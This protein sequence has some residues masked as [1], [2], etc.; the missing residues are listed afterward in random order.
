MKGCPGASLQSTFPTE[1]EMNEP[2]GKEEENYVVPHT[3]DI[4]PTRYAQ[5]AWGVTDAS[6]H[7][8]AVPT[9]TRHLLDEKKLLT[10]STAALDDKIAGVETR[11]MKKKRKAAA[12]KQVEIAVVADSK[13]SYAPLIFAFLFGLAG[14]LLVRWLF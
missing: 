8:F 6:A 5:E 12:A 14:F 1:K 13:R 4:A 10:E 2:K 7:A 11:S 3:V 9:Q